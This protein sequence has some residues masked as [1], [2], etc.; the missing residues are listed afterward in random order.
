MKN[1]TWLITGA[2]RGLGLSIAKSALSAGYNVV[3]TARDTDSLKSKLGN[4]NQ[5]LLILPLDVTN[6]TQIAATIAAACDHFGGIDVLIN[7][8]GYGLLGAFEQ[9]QKT[10]IEHQFSTNVFGVFEMCRAVLPL[11]RKKRSGHIF[12]I[13]SIAGVN[14]MAGASVYSA[15]KFAVSG[16]SEALAQ[17]VA[18]FGIKVTAVQPGAFQTDFLDPSS[19]HFADQGIEDYNA[20]SEKIVAASNANNHQQKGDPDKLALALL[21]LS[22]DADVPPRFLAGSDAINMANSRL[23][24]LG[25]E[26]QNWENLSRSTDNG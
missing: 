1:K 16:F 7:N 21:T 6:G 23:A 12:N 25:A 8:A 17:E 24:T 19:A 26:L 5:H 20:F 18:G 22:N 13:S 2:A 3:A 15:S 11:M 4:K 9:T 14:A 10:Q